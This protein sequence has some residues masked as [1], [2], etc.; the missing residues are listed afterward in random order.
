MTETNF[1]G[2]IKNSL[3]LGKRRTK[4][5]RGFNKE[6]VKNKIDVYFH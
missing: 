3:P 1:N 2:K 4:E 6:E 5:Y